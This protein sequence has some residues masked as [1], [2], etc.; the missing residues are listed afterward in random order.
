MNTEKTITL[1]GKEVKILY[2]TATENGFEELSDKSISVFLPTFGEDEDGKSV[3]TEPA[4][5][6]IGDFVKLAIAGIIAAY[7]KEDQE[8]PVSTKDILFNT[9]PAERNELVTAIV[10]VRNEWYEISKV[11]EESIKAEQENS[12]DG[13]GETPKNA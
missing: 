8:P 4:K 9:K 2:C 13:K 7:A 6:N 1:C 12:Q 11:L 10:S 5:A 3:I